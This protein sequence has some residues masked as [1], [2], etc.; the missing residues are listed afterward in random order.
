[1]LKLSLFALMYYSLIISPSICSTTSISKS[2]FHSPNYKESNQPRHT[3]RWRRSSNAN[4][5]Q[6]YFENEIS[7]PNIAAVDHLTTY[8]GQCDMP[9]NLG[10]FKM[11]SYHYTSLTQKLEPIVMLSGDIQGRENVLVRI[12][13]QCFTSEVFGSLRC[14]CRDQLQESLKMIQ[15][16]GGALIYLQQEGRGIGAANKV[17]AYSL[18][19]QGED[20]VD[21]NKILGFKDDLREYK[22]VPEILKDLG[23]KSIRLLTNNP[24]KIDEL[25]KLGVVI[26]E[27]VSIQIKSNF[28]NQKYLRTKKERM[29]HFL[30]DHTLSYNEVINDPIS[31]SAQNIFIG[32]HALDKQTSNFELP[33][34]DLNSDEN[35]GLVGNEIKNEVVIDKNSIVNE[36]SNIE[37]N[38]S[39][40]DT[41]S[42][43]HLENN[44]NE[45]RIENVKYGNA[46]KPLNSSYVFGK[47]SVESAIQSL[48][49][50]K[51]IIVVDD[52]NRENEGDFIMAAEKATEETI[53]FIVRYSSGVICIS[54]ESERLEEL[55]LPPMVINNEDPKQTAY[56]VSVDCKVN[57]TTG[58]SASDRARTFRKLA[59]PHAVVSDFQRPGHVFPLRY[60]KGGV[61]ARA[62]HTEASLDLTRIAGLFPAGVLAEV[63]NDDGSMKRLEGLQ[64]MSEEKNLVLTSV[65]DIIAYRLEMNL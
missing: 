49:D 60:K 24:Y 19:D 48:K 30:S 54:M 17:A 45:V 47:Q 61:L 23:I 38:V 46:S 64:V 8:V 58:I 36:E 27:R 15:N 4:K 56:T 20:T 7:A 22:S 51:V 32:T 62:G 44:S 52:A 11:R 57:T 18:Q 37:S 14:D 35:I 31:D 10:K 65:Q 43:E 2:D 33:K 29:N 13:D 50:G 12:H 6:K 41:V 55:A 9:T 40:E 59:D 21:A 53:G 16:E 1:M 39:V 42:E 5:P 28:Y 25:T 34:Q 3:K 63:V 26:T